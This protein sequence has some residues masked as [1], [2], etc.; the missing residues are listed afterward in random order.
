MSEQQACR[1]CLSLGS[2]P[3]GDDDVVVVLPVRSLR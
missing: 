1:R 3:R 2:I